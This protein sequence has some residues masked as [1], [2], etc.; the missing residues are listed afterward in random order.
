LKLTEAE[1]ARL[2][3]DLLATLEPDV[4]GA[5]RDSTEIAK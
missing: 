4:R 5:I 1:R 2:V 3:T